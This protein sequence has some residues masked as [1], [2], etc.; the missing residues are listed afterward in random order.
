MDA[1]GGDEVTK[2][3][4]CRVLKSVP[5]AQNTAEPSFAPGAE[6][7]AHHSAE[8]FGPDAT[9]CRVVDSHP[10]PNLIGQILDRY[11]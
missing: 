6:D 4:E 1:V 7:T 8:G 9:R 3:I 10:K 11:A 5:L 2:Q